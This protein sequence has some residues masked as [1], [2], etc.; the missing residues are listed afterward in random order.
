[1]STHN[2]NPTAVPSRTARL[3]MI[4]LS[5]LLALFVFAS[6]TFIHEAGHALFGLAF[7]LTL[8]EFDVKFWNFNPHVNMQGNLTSAQRMVQIAAGTA[9]PL[10]V[11]ALFISLVPRRTTLGLELLK[12]FSSFFVINTLLTWMIIP[13]FYL[14][15]QAPPTDDVTNFLRV[16]QMPPLLLTAVSL[17][18]YLLSWLLFWVKA[19]SLRRTLSRIRQ[20]DQADIM[21]GTRPLL[22]VLAG[23]T[24]FGLG[25][26]L[27]WNN[28][29]VPV[30]IQSAAPPPDFQPAATVDL[31][32]RA[33]ESETL[34]VITLDKSASLG[35]F[36]LIQNIETDYFDLSLNGPDGYQTVIWHGEDFYT[37]SVGASNMQEFALG[38][39]EYRLVLTARQTPGL[40]S[41]AWGLR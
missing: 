30:V 26:V 28:T 15:K 25:V 22:G 18:L 23:L 4:T 27:M 38:P 39:G 5:L 40:L 37:D 1:M 11:W 8:T 21:A 10:V 33:Y 12:V 34:A 2:V 32:T 20:A 41:V 35:V 3:K 36:A 31:S 19:D 7:G 16:S 14:A 29:A 17:L 6:Y 9:L 24:A 13:L